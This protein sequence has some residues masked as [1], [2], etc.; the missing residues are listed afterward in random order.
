M[1]IHPNQPNPNAQLDALCADSIDD[2][3]ARQLNE[4]FADR[5]MADT[6]SAGQRFGD[7][8]LPCEQPPPAVTA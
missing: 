6:E 8:A 3:D 2:A 5:R 7:E 4:R 1:R